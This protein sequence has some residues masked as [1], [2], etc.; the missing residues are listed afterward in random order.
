VTTHLKLLG[1]GRTPARHPGISAKP[2]I[3]LYGDEAP[4]VLA[5]AGADDELGG[6][7]TQAMVR[8]SA[9]YEY[10]HTVEDVLARRSRLLFLDARLAASLATRVGE[11][12]RQETG[13]DPKIAEFLGLAQ[14][15]LTVP[16]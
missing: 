11:I 15:Y 13:L 5:L 9:Q 16:E 4:A 1:G 6:G 3:H 8:F 2:G 12:L 7:L 14:A 10:A